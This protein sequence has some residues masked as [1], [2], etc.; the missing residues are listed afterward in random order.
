MLL[1]TARVQGVVLRERSQFLLAFA[2]GERLL[3]C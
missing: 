1:G 3:L 2:I